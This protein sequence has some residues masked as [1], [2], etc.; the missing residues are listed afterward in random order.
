MEGSHTQRGREYLTAEHLACLVPPRVC[1]TVSGV[2]P[3]H[4]KRGLAGSPNRAL[5]AGPLQPGACVGGVCVSGRRGE[6]E[7]SPGVRWVRSFS[8]SRCYYQ[9]YL[10]RV[11][12]TVGQHCK[13]VNM[14]VPLFCGCNQAGM[15]HIQVHCFCM[16]ERQG[17]EKQ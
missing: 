6:N 2:Q 16:Y 11:V 17:K 4:H 14:C 9:I 8:F 3:F 13:Q 1:L 10:G 15:C 12:I 5:S 7:I